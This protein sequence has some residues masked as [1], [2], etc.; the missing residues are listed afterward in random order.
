MATVKTITLTGDTRI[1]GLMSGLAWNSALTFGFPTAGSLYGQPYG[2]NEPSGFVAASVAMQQAAR[3][4]LTGTTLAGAGGN[5]VLKGMGVTDF[6]NLQLTEG[7]GGSADIR[8]ASST[9]VSN[10]TTPGTAWA[11]SPGQEEGGDA[12]FGTYYASVY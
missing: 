5:A 6:T 3:A 9:V 2:Y 11:Y 7:S 4:A 1:D 8:I 12:W 10:A